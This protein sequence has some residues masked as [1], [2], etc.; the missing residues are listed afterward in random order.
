[1]ANSYEREMQNHGVQLRALIRD[2]LQVPTAALM[3]LGE[4]QPVEIDSDVCP[5]TGQHFEAGLSEVEKFDQ[6][7]RNHS[8]RLSGLQEE[9]DI[10]VVCTHEEIQFRTLHDEDFDPTDIEQVRRC[11]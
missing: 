9:G 11:Y 4:I 2:A 3:E 6:I 1:M 7:S 10:C 8:E 5:V